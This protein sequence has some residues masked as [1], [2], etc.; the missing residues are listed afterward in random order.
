MQLGVFYYGFPGVIEVAEG[1]SE[2]AIV[3]VYIKGL[4]HEDSVTF[5]G[6]VFAQVPAS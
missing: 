3:H 2:A 6:F 5:R 1:A 4:R